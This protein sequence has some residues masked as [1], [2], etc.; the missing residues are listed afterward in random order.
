MA[1]VSGTVDSIGERMVN[2]K[3]GL[4]KVYDLYIGGNKYGFGFKAPSSMGISVGTAVEF[5]TKGTY[6]NVDEGTLKISSSSAPGTVSTPATTGATVASLVP[7]MVSQG[8]GG[9]NAVFPVPV[10]HGDY[11][12]IRQN[13]LTNARELVTSVAYTGTGS[14]E[15]WSHVSSWEDLVDRVLKTAYIFEDYTS[16]QREVKAA[17]Q[18]HSSKKMSEAA[19]VM[20]NM[21]EIK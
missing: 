11:A 3:R 2:G 21:A 18:L 10:T 20:A 8:G 6:N 9:R 15:H 17:K 14:E 16:G 19:E 4:V 5:D 7:R 13:A 12:I 1:M